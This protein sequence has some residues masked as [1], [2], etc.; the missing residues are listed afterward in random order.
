MDTNGELYKKIEDYFGL[1]GDKA[2]E[3]AKKLKLTRE[4]AECLSHI[5]LTHEITMLQ[6][7][8]DK[9]IGKSAISLV[10]KLPYVS[11]H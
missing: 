8:Y 4:E 10:A 9:A 11:V 6:E 2:E 3:K 1:K 7:A 5:V